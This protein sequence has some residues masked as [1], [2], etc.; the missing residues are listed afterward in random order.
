MVVMVVVMVVVVLV[1]VPCV[2]LVV[3][4]VRSSS[5]A[6]QVDRQA[7][8]G[9]AGWP[10]E[11]DRPAARAGACTDS[12]AI[13]SATR[14]ATTALAKPPSTPT[15]PVPKLKRGFVGV[16]AG[17]AVGEE[18]RCRAPRRG[19]AMCQPSASSAIEPKRQPA[20]ISADHHDR[21]ERYHAQRAGF[22]AAA[23]AAEIVV[24]RQPLMS[25][26]CIEAKVRVRSWQDYTKGCARVRPVRGRGT[27]G[28]RP[29][30]SRCRSGCRRTPRSVCAMPAAPAASTGCA[31]RSGCGTGRAS[32][33]RCRCRAATSRFAR[34]SPTRLTG[35][36]ACQRLQRASI[37][38]PVSRLNGS[39][40]AVGR[41]RVRVVGRRHAQVH[42]RVALGRR[43]LVLRPHLPR[44]SAARGRRRARGRS[45]SRWP[46][47][48]SYAAGRALRRAVPGELVQRVRPVVRSRRSRS[49]RRP[50]GPRSRPSAARTSC[51]G[52]S[53]RS[54]P[55]TCRSSRGARA[56]RACG[57]RGR[58]TGRS[59]A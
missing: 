54:R 10:V 4:V 2:V 1:L 56:R 28:S 36:C 53:R 27:A 31:C 15:L 14:P 41:P 6:D 17:V 46:A 44:G 59:P 49:R 52:R 35:S 48:A 30:G 55:T 38:S 11:V 20:T 29:S 39:A 22:G 9:D 23:V 18:R 5:A 57:T 51:R 45:P 37:S 50:S 24:W 26:S 47:R 43:E 33:S 19:C 42:D 21:G 40:E 13:T 8:H 3:V 25:W 32:R 16:A 34:C 12:S 7:D 58:R